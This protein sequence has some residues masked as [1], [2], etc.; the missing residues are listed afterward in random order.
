MHFTLEDRTENL[1]PKLILV[2]LKHKQVLHVRYTF[3]PAGITCSALIF[4]NNGMITYDPA[5][6]VTFSFG[7]SAT[8]TCSEGFFLEGNEVRIC[9]GDGLS[10]T[11]SWDGTTSICSGTKRYVCM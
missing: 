2:L 8:H 9:S 4:V 6:S 10:V 7:T 3:F 5:G 1:C 11:G